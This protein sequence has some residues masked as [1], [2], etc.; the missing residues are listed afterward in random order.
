VELTEAERREA[1]AAFADLKQIF[2]DQ[3][4][5]IRH[6]LFPFFLDRSG[7]R[8]QW[9]IGFATLLKS[10]SRHSDFSR[11]INDLREPSKFDERMEVLSIV[12]ILLSAGFSFA[13]DTQISINGRPKKPD[14]FVQLDQSDPGFYIEVTSLIPSEK[15]REANDVFHA[16]TDALLPFICQLDYSGRL[17][18]ILAPPHLQEIL[19]T[20]QSAARKAA[21]ETGF[22]SIEIKGVI[23]LALAA[24]AQRDELDN[25]AR[26]RGLEPRSFAGPSVDVSEIARISRTLKEEQ[27]QVPPDR[28][29][30]VVIYSHFFAMPPADAT[31]FE[32]YVHLLEEAVF[33][34]SHIGYFN[35]DIQ[36]ARGKRQRCHSMS[37]SHLCQPPAISFDSDA[38]MLFKNR[39]ADKPMPAMAEEKFRNAFIKSAVRH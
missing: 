27:V 39:F 9:A 10:I 31:S 24:K 14:I 15:E 6:S 29:N 16:I 7:W 8:C 20:V 18:R 30:V 1:A 21:N 22:E 23:T 19:Q 26:K 3:F 32:Q 34:Y 35:F 33:K 11:L 17:E 37:R 38:T 4:F 13:L 12:D 5:D 28:T 25:W 2:S 36:M